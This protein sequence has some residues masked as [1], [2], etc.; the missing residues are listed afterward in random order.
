M[1]NTQNNKR[2]PKTRKTRSEKMGLEEDPYFDRW[3]SKLV[4]L[5]EFNH[6]DRAQRDLEHLQ[7]HE[8]VTYP[9]WHGTVPVVH[10]LQWLAAEC[11]RSSVREESGARQDAFLDRWG[12]FHLV[13]YSFIASKFKEDAENWK[14]LAAAVKKTLAEQKSRKCTLLQ[15]KC[16]VTRSLTRFQNHLPRFQI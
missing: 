3:K 5:V 9:S 16:P 6:A 1:C 11:V 10:Q 8:W 2:T 14:L 7:T 4:K 12:C 13:V 15:Q